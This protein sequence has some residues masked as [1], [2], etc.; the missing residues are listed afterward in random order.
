MSEFRSEYPRGFFVSTLI[1]CPMDKTQQFAGTMAVVN[2]RVEYFGNF[3]F[4]FIINSDW[5]QWGLNVIRNRIRS[6]WFQHGNM[7]YRVYSTKTVR[8]L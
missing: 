6:C 2:L 3:K 5:Q 4:W 7:E 8:K 1:T